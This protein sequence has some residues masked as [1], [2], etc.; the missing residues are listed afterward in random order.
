VGKTNERSDF[1]LSYRLG[2]ESGRDGATGTSTPTTNISQNL[3]FIL[4]AVGFSR[5]DQL[6]R[7]ASYAL[8]LSVPKH[9]N[10][11]RISNH[12]PISQSSISRTLSTDAI[13]TQ[14]ITSARI[15]TRT[16]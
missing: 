9:V 14:S 11:T 16:I 10:E 4:K 3:S 6:Y 8:A 12:I 1:I 15:K 13:S 7:A 5:K 2:Q